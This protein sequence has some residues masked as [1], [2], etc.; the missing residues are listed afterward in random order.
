MYIFVKNNFCGV[1]YID[2]H[3]KA[4]KPALAKLAFNKLKINTKQTREWWVNQ[5]SS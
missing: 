3:A 5:Q 2:D 1:Y 4:E